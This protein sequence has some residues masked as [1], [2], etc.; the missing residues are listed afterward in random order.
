MAGNSAP[1][2]PPRRRRTQEE[3]RAETR[4]RV[5]DATIACL[6][7]LGYGATTQRAVADRSGVTRGAQLHHFPTRAQLVAEATTRLA[8]QVTSRL[9]RQISELPR[10]KKRTEAALDL[11]WASFSDGLFIVALELW[12]ASRTD[13]ELAQALGEAEDQIAVAVMNFGHEIFG[14]DVSAR[15]QFEQ[16]LLF[17]LTVMRGLA[18]SRPFQPGDRGLAPRWEFARCQLLGLFSQA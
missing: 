9:E 6:L 5:L 10:G 15:P 3:R 2:A 11:L 13:A 14:P 16:R 17:A 4:A 12:L 7:E 8:S 18:T 1:A